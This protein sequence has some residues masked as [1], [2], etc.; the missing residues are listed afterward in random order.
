[1]KG[2]DYL[3][4]LPKDMLPK[5]ADNFMNSLEMEV[6][7]YTAADDGRVVR[8]EAQMLQADADALNALL[9]SYIGSFNA[10]VSIKS[11]IAEFDVECK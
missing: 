6:V 9:M 8:V 7:R 2:K 10:D 1:M 5:G 11:M 3:Y 4:Y